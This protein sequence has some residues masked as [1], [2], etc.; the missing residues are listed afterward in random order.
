MNK[1]VIY[2]VSSRLPYISSD[3]MNIRYIQLCASMICIALLTSLQLYVKEQTKISKTMLL[4]YV[5]NR[6]I[7]TPVKE[8]NITLCPQGRPKPTI[9]DILCMVFISLFLLHSNKR[10][11]IQRCCT[12]C[13]S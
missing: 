1:N 7:P 6:P 8:L 4:P 12:N 13:Q 9:D 2:N 3:M 5:P 11:S 10:K